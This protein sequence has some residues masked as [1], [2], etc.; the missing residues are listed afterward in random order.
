MSRRAF[1]LI[2]LLVVIAIIAI[3]A[4]I[5]FPVFN[6]AREKARQATCVSNLNQIGKAAQMYAQDYDETFCPWTGQYHNS[7]LRWQ[8]RYMFPGLLDP[9][10][11]NG[12]NFNNGDIK[13]VWACPSAKAGLASYSN[14]YAYNYWTFGGLNLGGTLNHYDPAVWG[15]YSSAEY[16][17][18]ASLASIAK[19]AETLFIVEGAQLC[20]P[21]QY[22]IVFPSGDPYYIGVW[23]PH[24]RGKGNVPTTVTSNQYIKQMISGTLSVV[25]FAD[26]H[27]K[28]SPTQKWYHVDYVFEN[29][30]WRGQATDNTGWARNF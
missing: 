23:G 16:D 13:E 28:A 1:T 29:G 20:R 26:G 8:L 15:P 10:V 11:K 6:Q 30:A 7:S 14:T 21:P 19:P 2:E 5:L 9:Y 3:L 12:L 25:L 18:P 22:K 17:K 27:V 24:Q 4:A